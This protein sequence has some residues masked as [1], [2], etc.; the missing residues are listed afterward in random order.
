MRDRIHEETQKKQK[1][2]DSVVKTARKRHSIILHRILRQSWWKVTETVV[3]V[4]T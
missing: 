3:Q 1:I 4:G 2:K